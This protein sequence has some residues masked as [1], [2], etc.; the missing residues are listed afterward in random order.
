[1]ILDR[2]ALILGSLTTF[3][4]FIIIPAILTPLG[5]FDIGMVPTPGSGAPSIDI[6]RAFYL[7][8]SFPGAIVAGYFQKSNLL[9]AILYGIGVEIIGILLPF[10][11]VV[12]ALALILSVLGG[13]FG[14]TALGTVFL[15][16]IMPQFVR[17]LAVIGAIGGVIGFLLG[18]WR[19][20]S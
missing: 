19:K 12:F 20:R 9:G 1:M 6:G 14:S 10:T 11:T 16:E 8:F 3:L 5:L 2:K 15:A 7:L 18:R 13:G 4:S 17:V